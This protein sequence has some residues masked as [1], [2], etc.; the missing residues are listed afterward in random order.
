MQGTFLYQNGSNRSFS[1]I[2]LS[3]DDKTSCFPVRVC[4]Q[5]EH[6]GSQKDHLQQIV[7][8]FVVLC[9]YRNE[10]GA[11]APVLRNQF[12][13]GELL[14]YTL[15][16]CAWF[17][18]LIDRN[19]DLNAGCFCMVD[20]LN[21]LR[22]H[23]VVCCDNENGDIRCIGST[24]THSGECLMSRGIEERNLLFVD[25]N[26]VCTDVL[27]NTASLAVGDM[28]VPD[29]V[30]KRCFTVVNVSHNADYRRTRNHVFFILFVLF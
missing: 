16:V 26:G 1:F 5:L 28:G 18:D 17:I 7:D 25:R 8:T 4:F 11:S 19:D 14:F 2:Q 30:Q 10:Y 29:A 6:F 27:G 15:Y 20:C 21:G 12:V 24:H 23:T 13:L 3:L 9:R 22:H